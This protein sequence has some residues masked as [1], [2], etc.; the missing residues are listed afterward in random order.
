[1]LTNHFIYLN[2]GPMVKYLLFK[3]GCHNPSLGFM[4]KAKAYKVAG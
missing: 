2:N 1:M 3:H 4:T